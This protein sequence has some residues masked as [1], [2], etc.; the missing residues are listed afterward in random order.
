MINGQKIAMLRKQHKLS[1]LDLAMMLGF[2]SGA[3]VGNWELNLRNCSDVDCFKL[4]QLFDVSLD[5]L[6]DNDT[7]ISQEV[8]ELI[9]RLKALSNK[10][11]KEMMNYLTFVEMRKEIGKSQKK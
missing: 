8:H 4:A 6:F 3:T 5:Y 9:E 1:Q 10:D 7:Y 11:L 2:K